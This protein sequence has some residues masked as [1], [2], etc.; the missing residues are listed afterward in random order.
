MTRADYLVLAEHDEKMAEWLMSRGIREE[1]DGPATLAVDE[2]WLS[3]R[4]S[5]RLWREKAEE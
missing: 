5:A 3:Y 4:E 1:L 2:L